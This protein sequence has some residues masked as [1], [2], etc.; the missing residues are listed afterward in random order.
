MVVHFGV[1]RAIIYFYYYLHFQGY[2]LPRVCLFSNCGVLQT[3]EE[4]NE[5]CQT[6]SRTCPSHSS[7]A[8]PNHRTLLQLTTPESCRAPA[9]FDDPKSYSG[10][11]PPLF[12]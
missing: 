8:R 6:T 11:G 3:D 1:K 9:I 5:V 7:M 12:R 2:A 10:R 4:T